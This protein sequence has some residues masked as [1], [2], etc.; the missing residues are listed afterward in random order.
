MS[1]NYN[2]SSLDICHWPETN[3]IRVM[4]ISGIPINL[5]QMTEGI[6]DDNTNNLFVKDGGF[7]DDAGDTIGVCEC[8]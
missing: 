5:L 1:N 6:V 2:H 4:Q 3:V 8:T 7:D